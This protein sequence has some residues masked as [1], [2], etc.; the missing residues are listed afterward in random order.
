MPKVKYDSFGTFPGRDIELRTS[1]RANISV[2]AR[3]DKQVNTLTGVNTSHVW[4]AI[5]AVE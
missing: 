5:S 1:G 2:L 4:E 3:Y